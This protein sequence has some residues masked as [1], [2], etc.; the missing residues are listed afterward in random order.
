MPKRKMSIKDAVG[1]L[2][3]ISEDIGRLET[4]MEI[5]LRQI[6]KFDAQIKENMDIRSIITVQGQFNTI[7]SNPNRLKFNT[8]FKNNPNRSVQE[9]AAIFENSSDPN[10]QELDVILEDFSD[11]IV[12]HYRKL[13]TRFQDNHD[14][15][16]EL[17]KTVEQYQAQLSP[18]SLEA[19]IANLQ[20]SFQEIS[21]NNTDLR[22]SLVKSTEQIDNYL[23]AIHTIIEKIRNRN[24]PSGPSCIQS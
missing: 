23:D 7:E 24:N 10:I 8:I 18:P 12:P 14:R 11:K 9:L 17:K 5:K 20:Q 15:L 21:T 13:K 4:S 19:D 16:K 2:K 6:G 1:E 3:A 22:L